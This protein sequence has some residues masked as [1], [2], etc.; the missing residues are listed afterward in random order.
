MM[1]SEA[2]AD[3]KKLRRHLLGRYPYPV[4]QYNQIG[5]TGDGEVSINLTDCAGTRLTISRGRGWGW[6]VEGEIQG[7][8]VSFEV[9]NRQRLLRELDTQF[10]E[11]GILMTYLGIEDLMEDENYGLG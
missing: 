11:A 7:I 5:Y 1:D 9:E 2:P 3:F 6:K 4:I 8:E 10:R